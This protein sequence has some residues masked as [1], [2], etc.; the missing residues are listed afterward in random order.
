MKN[1][2]VLAFENEYTAEQ[3]KARLLELQNQGLIILD[4]LVVVIRHSDGRSEVKQARTVATGAALGGAFW[5]M[6]IGLLFLSPILGAAIGAGIGAVVGH[7]R[8]LGVDEK[9]MKEVGSAL[10]PGTSGVFFLT[11]Q[12]TA[13][14]V[15]ENL[16]EYHPTVIRTN[17][18]SEQEARLRQAFSE[19]PAEKVAQQQ[20]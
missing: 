9:F 4:D 14:R 13:D 15:V 19:E 20:M 5:G 16:K 6:L 17:L 11:S 7:Y 18:T 1:L 10:K 12:V 8:D 2:V 3:V